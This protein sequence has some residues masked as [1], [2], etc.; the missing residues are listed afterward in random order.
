MSNDANRKTARGIMMFGLFILTLVMVHSA[1][2]GQWAKVLSVLGT[3]MVFG[4]FLI[5]KN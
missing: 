4:S 5:K 3:I 2:E 1:Y